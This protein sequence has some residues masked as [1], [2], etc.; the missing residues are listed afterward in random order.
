MEI[1]LTGKHVD[2]DEMLREYVDKKMGKLER[3]GVKLHDVHV[4]LAMEK[5]RALAEVS[6]NVDGHHLVAKEESKELSQ[7]IDS[8]I[9]KIE[10]QIVRHRGKRFGNRT[11][12]TG[13]RMDTAWGANDL[14]ARHDGVTI[15][16][17]PVDAMSIEEALA[18]MASLDDNCM[19]FSDAHAGRM[20][21]MH[22]RSDG[23][24]EIM[25]PLT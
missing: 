21:I 8:A 13:V 23:T 22:R 19:V 16:S 14:D 10:R 12:P 6:I 4:T 25:D 9:E 11:R 15:R 1:N 18:A 20:R 5:V 17:V 3:H 24:V 7:S 2:V